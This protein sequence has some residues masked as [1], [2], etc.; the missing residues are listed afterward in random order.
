VLE[1]KKGER[2]LTIMC[3]SL[4][5]SL[6]RSIVSKVLLSYHGEWKEMRRGVGEKGAF[7]THNIINREVCSVTVTKAHATKVISKEGKERRRNETSRGS[8]KC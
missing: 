2:K 4:Y 7:M 8:R 3:T 6:V 1:K 5:N